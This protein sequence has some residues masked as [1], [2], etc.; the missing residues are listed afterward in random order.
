MAHKAGVVGAESQGGRECSSKRVRPRVNKDFKDSQGQGQMNP[1]HHPDEP[2]L[3]GV[4]DP[5]PEAARRATSVP[6]P[7]Q[8]PRPARALPPGSRLLG[9]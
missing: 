4:G 7:P 5:I 8:R 6:K 2:P 3:P 9:P 1:I